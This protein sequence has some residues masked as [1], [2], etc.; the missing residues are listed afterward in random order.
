MLDGNGSAPLLHPPGQLV[1]DRI[2]EVEQLIASAHVHLGGQIEV[3]VLSGETFV[4]ICFQIAVVIVGELIG[5]GSAVVLEV[6]RAIA[7]RIVEDRGEFVAGIGIFG[8]VDYKKEGA[9][10]LHAPS[11]S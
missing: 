4:G 9:R 6:V 2:V 11:F 5:A 8:I 7:G 10:Q 3:I 1:A